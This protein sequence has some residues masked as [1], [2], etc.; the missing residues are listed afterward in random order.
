MVAWINTSF[1]L[2]SDY[3]S[4]YRYTTFCLLVHQL[5]DIWG[6]F[7]YFFDTMNNIAIRIHVFFFY[8]HIFIY[9]SIYIGVELLDDVV[10]LPLTF[11]SCTFLYPHKQSK[12]ILIYF[13]SFLL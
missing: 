10:T 13:L 2:L 5:T 11:C 8:G 12:K 9:I 3:M 6:V 1:L 7:S 4:L